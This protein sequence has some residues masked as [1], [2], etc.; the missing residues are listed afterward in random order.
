MLIHKYS[1]SQ[2]PFSFTTNIPEHFVHSVEDEHCKQFGK[3]VLHS[4]IKCKKKCF[5]LNEEATL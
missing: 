2:F 5:K 4:E 3:I 1:P